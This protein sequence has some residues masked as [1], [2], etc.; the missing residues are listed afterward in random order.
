MQKREGRQGRSGRS[1]ATGIVVRRPGLCGEGVGHCLVSGVVSALWRYY[2][3]FTL[4]PFSFAS[5]CSILTSFSG[6]AELPF[7]TLTLFFFFL[8]I[9]QLAQS[10]PASR[11]K[12]TSLFVSRWQPSIPTALCSLTP[13]SNKAPSHN[14]DAPTSWSSKWVNLFGTNTLATSRSRPLSV[15]WQSVSSTNCDGLNEHRYRLGGL[16]RAYLP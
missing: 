8:F 13:P 12:S 2:L 11:L 14:T 3:S 5:L 1:E 10:Y 9:T 15:C 16:F 7:L 6:R 4:S